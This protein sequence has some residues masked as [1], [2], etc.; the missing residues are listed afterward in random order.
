MFEGAQLAGFVAAV[1]VLVV[2]PGPNTMLILAHSL[3]RGRSAG[4]ATVLGIETGTLVHTGAAALGLSAILST[5]AVAFD[6]VK[7][8]G[9]AYLLFLGFRAL[10]GD[11]HALPSAAPGT[12]G[13]SDAYW[14]AVLTSVLNPKSALFF[15]ALLPQFVHPERGHTVLQFFAL[16]LIVSAVGLCFGSAL[17]ATAGTVRG[18]L[19]Q[20]AVARWQ[21]RVTGSVLLGLGMRLA[22]AQRE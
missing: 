15:L 12:L 6:L 19:G 3:G 11:G 2:V 8:A 21:R 9:A 4:L 18:W 13:V 20:N 22:L 5:S 17:A 10:R 7:Y 14:R 16:G 1:A